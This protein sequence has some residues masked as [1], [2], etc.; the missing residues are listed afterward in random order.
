M[1]AGNAT[2]IELMR[3]E[4]RQSGPLSF[5]R[6]MEHA[7]YHPQHGFYASNRARL[8]RAGDYFTNVSVG[9]AFGAMLGLQFTELRR[10]LGKPSLFQVVEQG[11]HHGHF[12]LDLLAWSKSS[13][14]DF[15]ETLQYRIIEPAAALKE[16]QRETLRAFAEK[17]VWAD[18]VEDVGPFCGVFFCNELI[19]AFPV[20]LISWSGQEWKERRVI[21]DRGGFAFTTEPIHDRNLAE[22]AAS[23]PR[24][25]KNYQTELNLVASRWIGAV[26]SRLDRGFLIAI[27]YGYTAEQYYSEKRTTGTLQVRKDHHLL[28]SPFEEVGQADI[29][30]HVDWSSL[31]KAGEAAGM[32][33]LGLPD[34]H[35]FLTGILSASSDFLSQSGPKIRRQLQTLLHPEMLG[36]SFQVLVMSRGVETHAPIAGVRFAER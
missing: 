1:S 4:I 5:A 10:A 9:S 7:L 31:I 14:P 2:L 26:A 6:F 13:A 24:P 32:R 11:A 18:A 19:D 20:H 30:A 22:H 23:L 12:A 28:S 36:R 27:D 33:L 8:G 29:T 3:E 21:T 34:Q 15:F 35:H 25:A 17:V 16:R